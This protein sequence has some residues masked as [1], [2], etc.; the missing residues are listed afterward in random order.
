MKS[1][2]DLY[3]K[4][5]KHFP[6]TIL[7]SKLGWTWWFDRINHDSMI[8]MIQ[9]WGLKCIVQSKSWIPFANSSEIRSKVRSVN[10]CL[11]FS[12]KIAKQILYHHTKLSFCHFGMQQNFQTL[13]FKWRWF[14]RKKTSIQHQNTSIQVSKQSSNLLYPYF[15]GVGFYYDHV[16]W[17]VCPTAIL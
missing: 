4:R 7:K 6:K 5:K 11:I 14:R 13:F 16:V 2:L 8:I 17:L 15:S 3:K 10:F 1:N 9:C 12:K